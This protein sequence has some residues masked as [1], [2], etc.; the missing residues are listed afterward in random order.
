MKLSVIPVDD[1]IT[2]FI[3]I[4]VCPLVIKMLNFSQMWVKIKVYFFYIQIHRP[5]EICPLI[6]A[7]SIDAS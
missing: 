2:D 1:K 4:A 6:L 3:N 7:K 5:L